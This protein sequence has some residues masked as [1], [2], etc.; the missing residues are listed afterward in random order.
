MLDIPK[1]L[2]NINDIFEVTTMPLIMDGDTGGRPE[3]FSINIR[4][5]ER[6]GVSAVVIEDKQGLKKNSLFGNDVVQKQET[7]E[8][9]YAKPPFSAYNVI[10][11]SIS[12][13]MRERP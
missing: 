13:V 11:H 12:S 8:S 4:S 10:D 5:L 2:A 6:V 9:F 1:R 7:T 3:H